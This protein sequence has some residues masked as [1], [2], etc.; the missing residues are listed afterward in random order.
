MPA[1]VASRNLPSQM[2][3]PAIAASAK[4]SLASPWHTRD[5]PALPG[6]PCLGIPSHLASNDIWFHSFYA[7]LPACS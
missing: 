1:I 5:H 7:H 3:K 2:A 6:A 4:H